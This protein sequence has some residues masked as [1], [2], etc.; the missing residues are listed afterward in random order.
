MNEMIEQLNSAGA[1]FVAFALPMLIQSS[2]LIA[3]ILG[4]DMILRKKVRAVVRYCLWMLV[5]VKLVLPATLSA[6]TGIGYWIGGN[7]LSPAAQSP[8]ATPRPTS[9]LTPS[10]EVTGIF[11]LTEIATPSEIVPVSL[12]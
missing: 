4:L 5:L 3:V 10:Q 1:S 2:L 7:F 11:N 12:A 6:P 8:A 9:E